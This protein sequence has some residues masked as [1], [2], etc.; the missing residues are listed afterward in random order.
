MR[1]LFLP[2][3]FLILLS[4]AEF[5]IQTCVESPLVTSDDRRWSEICKM[6]YLSLLAF[7]AAMPGS[8]AEV[9]VFDGMCTALCFAFLS[10]VSL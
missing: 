8:P 4:C 10:Q 1:C 3:V 2:S 5:G 9:P 6:R 7:D